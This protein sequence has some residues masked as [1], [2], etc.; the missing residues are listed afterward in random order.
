MAR[1]CGSVRWSSRRA[2]NSALLEP[3]LLVS[4][5]PS[6]VKRGWHDARRCSATEV[7]QRFALA[8]RAQRRRMGRHV[9]PYR[10][11]LVIRQ[12]AQGP[13]DALAQEKILLS[14]R[15]FDTGKEQRHVGLRDQLALGDD[16]RSSEPNVLAPRPGE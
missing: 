4:L 8:E 11:G 1:S 3:P 10:G 2:F 7:T 9:P 16:R 13:A 12:R 5:R 6:Q 14:K 15:R